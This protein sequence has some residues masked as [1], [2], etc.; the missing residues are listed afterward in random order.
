MPTHEKRRMRSSKRRGANLTA[1]LC[2]DD[3]LVLL[4]KRASSDESLDGRRPALG[5]TPRP[6]PDRADAGAESTPCQRIKVANALVE[7][8]PEPTSRPGLP[9]R[10][11]YVRKFLASRVRRGPIQF[12]EI[13]AEAVLLR[14]RYAVMKE[15][16]R[17][18]RR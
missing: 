16:A 12:G 13:S 3:A 1:T 4:G 10:W 17:A 11:Y 8:T 9:T 2:V 18:R 5:P 6:T 15:A 7:A 14:R